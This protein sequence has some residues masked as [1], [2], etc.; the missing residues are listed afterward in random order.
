MVTAVAFVIGACGGERLSAPDDVNSPAFA[1]AGS[2]PTVTS[3]VP[4]DAPRD[5][6]L[7][8]RILG[9]G[10]DNGSRAEFL[11]DGV[12]DS[13]VHVNTTRF[14]ASNEIV[15]NLSIDADA[16]AALYDVAV[17]TSRGKKGIGAERFEVTLQ[18]QLLDGR[19]AS[20]VNQDGVVVGVSN[21]AVGCSPAALP[22]VWNAEG[23]KQ[24]LPTAP[25]CG[26]SAR[27]INRSGAIF[28]WLF[29]SSACDQLAIW[30]PNGLGYTLEVLG[31]AP[32]GVCPSVLSAFNEN[33]EIVGTKGA[34]VYWWS[35][36]TGWL[37]VQT[38]VGATSC[39]WAVA[40]NDFGA[41]AIQCTVG[42]TARAYYWEHHDAAPSL[43]PSPSVQ[44]QPTPRAMNRSGVIVGYVYGRRTLPIRWVPSNSG[45]SVQ[46]LPDLGYGG[47]AAAISEDGTVAGSVNGMG[48]RA[49]YWTPL[50]ELRL[51]EQVSAKAPSEALGIVQSGAG[52]IV[53][54]RGARTFQDSLVAVRWSSPVTP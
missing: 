52:L 40:L 3:T 12:S 38:P 51:L 1:K 42:G 11:L 34:A 18:A 20:S 54:G 43:L 23:V 22:V 19:E 33:A 24:I 48:V 41:F 21:G 7:D 5:T 36:A 30:R 15:A 6:T 27:S 29:S 45:Y 37:K 14:V 32:D 35:A 26:G 9:S 53:V 4:S 2:G 16:A 44:G 50:G 17:T 49:A 31:P 8:V 46:V 25:A 39:I 13:R 47:S 10:F 28:G